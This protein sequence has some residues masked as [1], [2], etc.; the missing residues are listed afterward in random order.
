MT[1]V[2]GH[3]TTPSTAEGVVPIGELLLRNARLAPDA[4]AVVF[5]DERWSYAELADRAWA[6]SRGLAGLGVRPGGRVGVLMPNCPEFI[7]CL[8]GIALLGAVFVPVNA[9]YRAAELRFLV[10]DAEL[11]VIVTT[12]L[13]DEYLDF[14]ALLRESI[15]GLA[16]ATAPLDVRVPGAPALRSV[17]LLGERSPA[18]LVDR[19][20][21][22][23]L[24]AGVET[25]T[26]ERWRQGVALRSLATIMYTSGTTAQPRG[27]LQTHEALVRDW[28]NVGAVLSFTADD[29]MWDALPMFHLGGI[30]PLLLT[31]AAGGAFLSTRFFE[32]SSALDQIEG[33]R[34]TVLWSA[35]PPIMQG[36]LTHPR[37]G[38]TDVSSLRAMCNVA[39]AETLRG[40]QEAIP[41]ATQF[42]T[43][44]LTE[45][46]MV[47]VTRLE[48]ELEARLA[49]DGQPLPGLEVRAV[50]PETGRDQP[51]DVPGEILVRGYSVCEG[52]HNDPEKTAASLDGDGWLHTGDLGR[53]DE[54][55]RMTFVGRSKEMLKVGGENV[56]PAEIEAQLTT[57]PAVRLVQVVGIPDERLVEV[58]VAFVE[59]VDGTEAGEEELI[60]HCRDRIARFKVPRQV[61]F[62]TEWPM[63]ATKI[64][65]FR[66]R[67]QLL[68]EMGLALPDVTA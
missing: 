19:R 26:L 62:V 27:A 41:H 8:F 29:R 59:L 43:F 60:A 11:E 44:A 36:L 53:L 14:V 28:V 49:T 15:D 54:R 10:A 32:A 33:E 2:A 66:L 67:E 38:A 58:P 55:G 7:A 31:I 64:Q 68:A 23:A 37:F 46:G 18:G 52:Y 24:A 63:S 40:F 42:S 51:P 25:E 4:E 57:H 30:G 35:Y 47:T 17:V 6:I 65:R 20:R 45:A 50:D 5:P 39:P 34:A 21:F 9:R 1:G 22:D 56:A 16:D 61:R 13:T 12:D 48:D 3:P